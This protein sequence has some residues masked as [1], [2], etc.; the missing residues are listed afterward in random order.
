MEHLLKI[1][2]FSLLAG[3]NR[4]NLIFYDEIG[5][6]SPERVMD[7]GYRFYSHRQLETVSVIISLQEVGMPLREIKQYLDERTPASLIELFFAQRKN[8]ENKIRRLERSEAM[9]DTRLGITRRALEIDPTAIE[10]RVCAEE[11][12]FAGDEIHCGGTEA[13]LD[14][15]A[16][17]FYTLCDREKITYGYPFGTMILRQNL[18]A[19]NWRLPSRFFFKMPAEDGARPMLSKP[20]GSYLIGYECTSCKESQEV[21]ARLFAFAKKQ[22]LA[23]VGN[24]YEEYLLDEITVKNPEDYL[25]QVSI[26]VQK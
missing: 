23:I 2:E 13:E 20:A 10:L 15:A 17:E 11:Q 26:Q 7:N 9:I 21:Y 6:L 3:I 16:T 8:M 12:L 14:N 22:K 5:L 25:L 18:I 1:S 4:K 24:S 19:G